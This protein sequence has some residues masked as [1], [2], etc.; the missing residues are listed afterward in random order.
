MPIFLYS[1]V[2]SMNSLTKLT[3]QVYSELSVL[4]QGTKETQKA[5]NELKEMNGKV[6]R[7]ILVNDSQT[8]LYLCSRPRSI[9]DLSTSLIV[10]RVQHVWFSHLENL[11]F[12]PEKHFKQVLICLLA[13]KQTCQV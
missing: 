8:S 5:I 9:L 12:A 6:D 1:L 13:T 10:S 7:T 4:A 3:H 11:Y 2:T